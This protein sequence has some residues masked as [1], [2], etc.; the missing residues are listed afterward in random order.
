MGLLFF[1]PFLPAQKTKQKTA[2]GGL[3][4][5]RVLKPP[6]EGMH[7]LRK[8]ALPG[9]VP[10]AGAPLS[11]GKPCR[12]AKKRSAAG[13]DKRLRRARFVIQCLC[14][15]TIRLGLSRYSRNSR[16]KF[17]AEAFFQKGRKKTPSKRHCIH[18]GAGLPR[19][20]S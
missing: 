11:L 4:L 16:T 15:Q 10:I 19:K 8:K 9:G 17:F 14:V 13:M 18:R 5:P 3:P 12:R 7:P 20:G 6:P 2:G 1:F